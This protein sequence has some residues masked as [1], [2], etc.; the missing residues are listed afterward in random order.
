MWALFSNDNLTNSTKQPILCTQKHTAKRARLQCRY[1]IKRSLFRHCGARFHCIVCVHSKRFV[2]IVGVIYFCYV[3]KKLSAL[4]LFSSH[5]SV[6]L[7]PNLFGALVCSRFLPRYFQIN[8][9]VLRQCNYSC[10]GSTAFL[11]HIDVSATF[12]YVPYGSGQC[13]QQ[14][15]TPKQKRT[16]IAFSCHR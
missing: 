14:V 12:V 1:A 7:R 4:L 13:R 3:P 5:F 2:S 10:K 15:N 8:A 16:K 9:P 6:R 11:L